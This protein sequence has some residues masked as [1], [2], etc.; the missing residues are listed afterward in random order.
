L[1]R[2]LQHGNLVVAEGMARELGRIS[3]SEA[4]ELTIL[5]AR[6]E[7]QRLPKVGV[8]WL[9][10]YLHEREPTLAYV[11]LAVSALGALPDDHER[12]RLEC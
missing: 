12:K 1:A 11:S 6:K 9:E 5:I 8:R 2:A 3:L 10:R 7:P 4:L